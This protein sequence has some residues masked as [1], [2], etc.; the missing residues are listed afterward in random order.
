[1]VLISFVI[2]SRLCW[3]AGCDLS[4]FVGDADQLQCTNQ[5]GDELV[6]LALVIVRQ[7]SQDSVALR[8]D[9]QGDAAAIR[10]VVLAVD[11]P[12]F[13]TALAEF[14]DSVM[15]QAQA[16]RYVRYR[17]LRAV[18]SSSDVEQEL[19]LLRV[20]ARVCGTGFAEMEKLSQGVAE[21]G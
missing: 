12:S 21:L 5:F 20:K 10:C 8:G 17:R 16:F 15:S 19:V 14:D 13:F 7:G 1:M 11:Q 3:A 4:G 18:R 2:S 9:V 6:Q